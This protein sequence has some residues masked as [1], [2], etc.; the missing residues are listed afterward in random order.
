MT[1]HSHTNQHMK[2]F[3]EKLQRDVDT[4]LEDLLA[5]LP[6]HEHV[7][8]FSVD[9]DVD[10]VLKSPTACGGHK[11]FSHYYGKHL[12]RSKPSSVHD[13]PRIAIGSFIQYA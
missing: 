11:N 5:Y 4:I 2:G 8:P 10:M 6:D 7:G 12:H 9:I 3:A 13:R 1:T